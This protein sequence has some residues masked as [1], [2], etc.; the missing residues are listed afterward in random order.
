VK[1]ELKAASARRNSRVI[2]SLPLVLC[3]EHEGK[4]SAHAPG[5][6]TL[7]VGKVRE[8]HGDVVAWQGDIRIEGGN[9]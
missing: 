1:V 2:P 4:R 8:A 9:G 5:Y 7:W 3:T 6:T